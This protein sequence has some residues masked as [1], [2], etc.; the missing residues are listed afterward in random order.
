MT[1]SYWLLFNN[2][3]ALVANDVKS[4]V[5]F[6]A[7]C[8]LRSYSNAF[9]FVDRKEA[10]KF[11]DIAMGVSVIEYIIC[12]LT[13]SD[14]STQLGYFTFSIQ[15]CFII[16]GPRDLALNDLIMRYPTHNIVAQI[17]DNCYTLQPISEEVELGCAAVDSL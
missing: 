15:I 13:F 2:R 4:F 6:R 8:N 9:W 16:V 14:A 3:V 11:I 12:E 10:N 1:L 5:F 17:V 7:G